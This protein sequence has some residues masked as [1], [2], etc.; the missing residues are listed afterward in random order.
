[1]GRKASIYTFLAEMQDTGAKNKVFVCIS[2]IWE[3]TTPRGTL[4]RTSVEM[5]GSSQLLVDD[6]SILQAGRGLWV[7]IV[8]CS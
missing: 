3:M 8:A 4:R 7:V 6:F 1:M 5:T 2:E